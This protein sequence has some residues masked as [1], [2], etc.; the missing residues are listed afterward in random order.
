M[1]EEKK[2]KLE[3]RSQT[4]TSL[5]KGLKKLAFSTKLPMIAKC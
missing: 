2:S 5:T 3:H 1:K 4:Y